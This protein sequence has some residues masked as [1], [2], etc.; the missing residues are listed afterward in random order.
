LV[1]TRD[2][3]QRLSELTVSLQA[4]QNNLSF[5]LYAMLSVYYLVIILKV[6]AEF[7]KESTNKNKYIDLIL[8]ISINGM[9]T[10]IDY[11]IKE[12]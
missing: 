6:E 7:N 9:K 1:I 3:R 4:F 12:V 8:E 2:S 11:Q 10:I 5:S